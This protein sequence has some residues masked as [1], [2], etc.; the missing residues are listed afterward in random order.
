MAALFRKLQ[1]LQNVPPGSLAGKICTVSDLATRLPEQIWFTEAAQAHDTNFADQIL[2]F[3]P[4]Q[5]LWIFDRGFFDFTFF[6]ALLAKGV[7][8]ITRAKSNTVCTVQHVLLQ[9]AEV[10]PIG[11][12]SWAVTRPALATLSA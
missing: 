3:A 1:A 6:K 5:T 8:W 7:A 4:T 12:Y 2:A 10:T 9:S 11:L